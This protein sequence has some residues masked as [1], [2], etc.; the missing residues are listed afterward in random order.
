MAFRIETIRITLS[1]LQGH[2]LT[3]SLFKCDFSYSCASVDNI[4]TDITRRAVSVL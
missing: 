3:T 4:S 1:D 2:S